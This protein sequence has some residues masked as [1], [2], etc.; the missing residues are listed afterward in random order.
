MLARSRLGRLAAVA[1]AAIAALVLA[2][3]SAGSAQTPARLGTGWHSGFTVSEYYPV[4]ER[5]FRGALTSAPGLPGRHRV[6]WLYSGT[7]LVMEADGVGLD[8]RRYHLEGG[9]RGWVNPAGRTT[10]ASR[11]GIWSRGDPAW[12]D[13]GW[14]TRT[15]H[16]TFPLTRGGWSAGRAA[17]F[18]RPRG[19]RFG[20]GPSLPLT[21]YR[22]V[23]VDPRVLRLGTRIYI[24][25]Y[26]GINGGWF[27]A[28]DTGPAI[29]GRHVDV[30]RPAPATPDAARFFTGRRVYVLPPGA[31]LDPH[32]GIPP[33][34]VR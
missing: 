29:I 9:P 2:G 13:A 14:R 8:G 32:A 5:W 19:V 31:R 16:V 11:S 30:Y 7:G 20:T 3:A 21:Y 33:P 17:R 28:D 18:V 27:R 1:V 10:V 15:G 25:T 24:P 4:P 26:R 12:I 22:S 23:A 34:P 6:D